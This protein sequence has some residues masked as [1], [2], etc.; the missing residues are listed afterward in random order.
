MDGSEVYL[1]EVWGVCLGAW[2]VYLVE[3]EVWMVQR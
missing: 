1:A 2:M 3:V